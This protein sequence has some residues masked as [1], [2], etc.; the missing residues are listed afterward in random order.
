[1]ARRGRQR[2]W[3]KERFWRSLLARWQ[4]SQQTVRDFCELH[5]LSEASFYAW[6]R[7]IAQRDR[8]AAKTP[9]ASTR[10]H[11][12]PAQ[13]GTQRLRSDDPGVA[14]PAF[15]PVRVC[16]PAAAAPALE[17]VLGTAPVVRVPP[18]FDPA[19]LRQLLAILEEPAC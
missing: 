6:R 12:Q 1:M 15:V 16:A 8:A 11:A 17:L 10:L 7:T 19:S 13:N 4:R 14:P 9:P 18:G 3:A 5:D 2:D